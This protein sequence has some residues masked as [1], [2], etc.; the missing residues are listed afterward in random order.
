MSDYKFFISFAL[1]LSLSLSLPHAHGRRTALC[2]IV[3][4]PD[5]NPTV[6]ASS[7]ALRSTG[8]VEDNGGSPVH[9]VEAYSASRRSNSTTPTRASTSL[10]VDIASCLLN[11][12]H[13]RRQLR[14]F[15]HDQVTDAE[16]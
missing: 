14:P 4:T 6:S 10:C 15:P 16:R 7:Q 5:H 12:T 9:V 8:V 3:L 2:R 11:C 1:W 13:C